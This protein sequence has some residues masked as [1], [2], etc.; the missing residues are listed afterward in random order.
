[1]KVKL[2]LLVIAVSALAVIGL[3]YR[4]I[5]DATTLAVGAVLNLVRAEPRA[6]VG[7]GYGCGAVIVESFYGSFR[8]SRAR[9]VIRRAALA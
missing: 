8:D 1:M 7:R 4:S 5:H 3:T 2:V 9:W 6:G